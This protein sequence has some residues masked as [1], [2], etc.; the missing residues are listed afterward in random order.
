MDTAMT[1]IKNT[2]NTKRMREKKSQRMTQKQNPMRETRMIRATRTIVPLTLKATNLKRRLHQ[3]TK[4]SRKTKCPR[5]KA[6]K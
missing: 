4:R 2:K 1:T 5:A 6:R 3:T